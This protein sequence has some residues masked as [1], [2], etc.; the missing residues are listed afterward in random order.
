MEAKS[1]LDVLPLSIFVQTKS[2]QTKQKGNLF[3]CCYCCV[4]FF[5]TFLCLLVDAFSLAISLKLQAF[6]KVVFILCSSKYV[7]IQLTHKVGF[8][9]FVS[10][11]EWKNTKLLFKESKMSESF[12]AVGFLFNSLCSLLS[13]SWICTA[14]ATSV[15]Y[16]FTRTT[17]GARSARFNSNLLAYGSNVFIMIWRA[18]SGSLPASLKRPNDVLSS[19]SFFSILYSSPQWEHKDRFSHQVK[20]TA[21]G[22]RPSGCVFKALLNTFAVVFSCV[23]AFLPL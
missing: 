4:L 6:L 15:T 2:Q 23:A 7:L 3:C 10:V 9:S 13:C 1:G 21:I 8:I 16:R 14:P 18:A 19:F 17:A 20:L 22:S 12:I 5:S 11:A